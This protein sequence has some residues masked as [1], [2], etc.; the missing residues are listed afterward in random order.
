[1]PETPDFNRIADVCLARVYEV[2]EKGL[3]AEHSVV[4]EQ[5]RQIWNARGAAD[6]AKL[7]TDDDD[8]LVRNCVTRMRQAVQTLDITRMNDIDDQTPTKV[9]EC[10][11]CHGR[12]LL[13]LTLVRDRAFPSHNGPASLPRRRWVP[14]GTSHSVGNVE[15][16]GQTEPHVLVTRCYVAES[17][18]AAPN[19][20]QR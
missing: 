18:P 19:T 7:E 5:L 10:P 17:R 15:I 2:R 13:T 14:T 20:T 16:M 9:V 11:A 4:V 3:I 6:R 12:V 8:D 1:M